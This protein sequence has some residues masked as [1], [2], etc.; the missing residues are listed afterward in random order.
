MGPSKG[1][2][3]VAI[4]KDVLAI[5]KGLHEAYN[6]DTGLSLSYAKFVEGIFTSYIMSDTGKRLMLKIHRDSLKN[7]PDYD[8]GT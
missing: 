4:S 5:S 6:R 1:R 3:N 8:E 2:L 7:S